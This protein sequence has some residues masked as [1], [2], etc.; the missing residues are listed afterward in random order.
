M[1]S[2]EISNRIT[3]ALMEKRLLTAEGAVR[4]DDLRDYI[5]VWE[6]EPMGPREAVGISLNNGKD[7][8][9]H[10]LALALL[11]RVAVPLPPSLP[12]TQRNAL[13]ERLGCHSV[14]TSA[15]IERVSSN[16]RHTVVRWPKEIY[17]VLHSSGSTGSP[18]A[19]PVT[20]DGMLNNARLVRSTLGLEAGTLH[21][22]SMS[23]CYS[24]G[25][26][27]SFLLPLLTSDRS[28]V[29]PLASALN[30]P[31][32]VEL[33][34]LQK[35]EVLWVNPT[36]LSMLKNRASSADMRSVRRIISCTAPLTRLQCM[37]AEETWD[38]PVLQ[39]YG[40]VETLIVS[41]EHPERKAQDSF[42]AGIILGGK[43]AVSLEE[44]SG[45]LYIQNG[46]VT[47]GYAFFDSKRVTFQLPEGSVAGKV[48]KTSDLA[49]IDNAN[50][51]FIIARSSNVIDVE[52]FKIGAEQLEDVVKS[53]TGVE[54]VAALG[55]VDAKS[56]MRPVLL[57]RFNKTVPFEMLA[58]AC[59]DRLGPKARPSEILPVDHIPLTD[60]G[61]I[62]RPSLFDF[63][64]RLT[65]RKSNP[66]PDDSKN[67]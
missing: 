44:S 65:G 56:T 64:E 40:L 1:R 37:D 33:I 61:K 51:L 58:Q 15:G 34:R 18:H 55:V 41:M 30:I 31:K 53:F 3:Q 32:W 10:Y 25:L 48:F 28:L 62:H 9:L 59:V 11:D 19:I 12:A 52:G 20:L 23:H 29:G 26:Y 47:P 13:W 6:R 42:S 17:W 8:L 16:L 36:C 27:N 39:S 66:L 60:N 4:L 35:P 38:C 43:S 67:A 45:F 57:V 22:G 5:R 54:E 7:C 46:S 24:S 49:S 14:V 2:T 63:Y 21:L 50:R